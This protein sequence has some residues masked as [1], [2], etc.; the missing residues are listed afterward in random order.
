MLG[1]V[2]LSIAV[3]MGLLKI[4]A[5]AEYARETVPITTKKRT[6]KKPAAKKPTATKKTATKKSAGVIDHTAGCV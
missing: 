6:A 1:A 4:K 2:I 5:Q 3:V